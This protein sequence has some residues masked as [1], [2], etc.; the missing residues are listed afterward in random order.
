MGVVLACPLNSQNTHPAVTS[1]IMSATVATANLLSGWDHLT[2]V[3]WR[4]FFFML[5]F[6]IRTEL[7]TLPR[8][9]HALFDDSRDCAIGSFPV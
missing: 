7:V 5:A 1:Q 3:R 8:W 4:V 6:E 2:D 9:D